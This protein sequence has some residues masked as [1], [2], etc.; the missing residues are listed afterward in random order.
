MAIRRAIRRQGLGA[1]RSAM[2]IVSELG[3]VKCL[4]LEY[5]SFLGQEQLLGNFLELISRSGFRF[6]LKEAYPKPLPF[7][8]REIFLNMD[9][10]VNLFCYR[11]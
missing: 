11:D 5:H 6:Y 10:L 7:I 1:M 3:K 8:N 2:R 9:L 4:F